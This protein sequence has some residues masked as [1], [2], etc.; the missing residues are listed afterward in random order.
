MG[1]KMADHMNPRETGLLEGAEVRKKKL[2]G[3][4]LSRFVNQIELEG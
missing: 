4:A 2:Q 1:V 3:V